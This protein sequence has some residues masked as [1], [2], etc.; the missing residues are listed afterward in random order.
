MSGIFRGWP[1]QVQFRTGAEPGRDFRPDF[2]FPDMHRQL[3]NDWF[4]VRPE[5]RRHTTH[6]LFQQHNR[7]FPGSGHGSQRRLQVFC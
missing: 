7:R 5:Y 3:E 1:D 2:H 6:V 4:Q